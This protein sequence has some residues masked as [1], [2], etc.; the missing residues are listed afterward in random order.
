MYKAFK[1]QP[2]GDPLRP[3]SFSALCDCGRVVFEVSG[4]ALNVN[5]P[6]GMDLKAQCRCGRL[7]SLG[8]EAI[9]EA[10]AAAAAAS[11]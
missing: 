5:V 10:K 1:F 6:E 2:V 9:A 7:H 4:L 3:Y 8:A 11:V